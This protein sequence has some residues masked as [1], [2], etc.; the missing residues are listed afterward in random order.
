MSV[1]LLLITHN[2]RLARA[3]DRTLLLQEGSTLI[4]RAIVAGGAA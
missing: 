3:V 2:E 4:G 1:G